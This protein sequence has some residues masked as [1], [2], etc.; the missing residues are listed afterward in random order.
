MTTQAQLDEEFRK[1]AAAYLNNAVS[2]GADRKAVLADW[3]N[4]TD[5]R[6]KQYVTEVSG[7]DLNPPKRA[8][9]GPGQGLN[10]PTQPLATTATNAGANVGGL[11]EQYAPYAA[12][13]VGTLL[14]AEAARRG[15]QAYQGYQAGKQDARLKAL[16]IEAAELS[17]QQLRN[18]LQG[19]QRDVTTAQ[20]LNTQVGTSV[21]PLNAEPVDRMAQLEARLRQGQA[22][23]LGAPAAPPVEVPPAPVAAPVAPPAAE[24]PRTAAALDANQPGS[25]VA[26]AVVKDELVKPAVPEA[27]KVA[28]AAEPPARTGSGQPAFPGTGPERARMPKGGTFASAADV[29]VGLAFVP[30]AQYYDSLANAVRS[31]EA[32]QAI[33]RTKGG[34][35][36]SDA[37]ARE[38]AGEALK[39]AGAP[40]RDVMLAEGKKP[41]TVSGIF[42]PVGATK[43]KAVKGA[44]ATG[45]LLAMA[46]LAQA[47]TSGEALETGANI[48]GA[49]LPPQIQAGLMALT[50]TSVASG[51]VPPD[52][53]AREEMAM[54]LGSPYGSTEFAK[55]KRQAE[56]MKQ[57]NAPLPDW[58]K[59]QAGAGRAWVNPPARR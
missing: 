4:S 44:G 10:P 2:S 58:M 29:P 16:Q 48:A 57:A 33:V 25:K 30:G 45:A 47:R 56:K 1:Q 5:P 7:E 18:S 31:R 8:E 51:T 20:T 59:P 42:K 49:I 22:A 9:T 24:A 50:G 37:Q 27:P 41:D 17:N 38:W 32:A 55:S 46:D 28:G 52:M 54:L 12:P 34:Y 39:A 14:A 43:S 23:G 11:V 21:S 19:V 35:P 40:T 15:V 6:L 26:E 3:S 13:V 53:R 36:V